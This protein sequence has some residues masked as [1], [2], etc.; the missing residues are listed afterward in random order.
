MKA[1]VISPYN[2]GNKGEHIKTNLRCIKKN[3]RSSK[4]K[5]KTVR[6]VQNFEHSNDDVDPAY[7]CF[8]YIL[9]ENRDYILHNLLI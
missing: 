2:M 4:L 1:M 9:S 5:N 3:A 8:R 6:K 7:P